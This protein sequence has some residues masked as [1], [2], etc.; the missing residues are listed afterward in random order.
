MYLSKNI[1]S[2][3]PSSSWGR[4]YQPRNRSYGIEWH[5]K[6][7]GVLNKGILFS[8][9]CYYVK[10][11]LKLFWKDAVFGWDGCGFGRWLRPPIRPASWWG[12]FWALQAS[13]FRDTHWNSVAACSLHENG[14]IQRLFCLS[15]YVP[16]RKSDIQ[17]ARIW[18]CA[19]HGVS[20]AL[21]PWSLS[22]TNRCP[23]HYCRAS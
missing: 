19:A 14:C 3:Q 11:I 13:G 17:S 18:S 5:H 7:Q 1:F 2:G 12:V 23:H 9:N 4:N 21:E 8:H 20:S 15:K 10:L 6:W 22:P 16:G